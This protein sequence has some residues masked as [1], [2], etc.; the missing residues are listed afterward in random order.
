MLKRFRSPFTY[1]MT[2]YFYSA[3]IIFTAI[4]GILSHNSGWISVFLL[5]VTSLLSAMWITM[6]SVKEKSN[7]LLL[8]PLFIL[9]AP[10]IIITVILIEIFIKIGDLIYD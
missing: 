5:F 6:E 2:T 1:I 8:T 9:I 10:G 4:I 7:L 3:M